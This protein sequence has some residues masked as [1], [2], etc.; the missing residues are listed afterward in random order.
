ME[1]RT[2]GTLKVVFLI[3]AIVAA[4]FGIVLLIVP[5]RVQLLV[6]WSP[7]DPVVSRVLG[8]ALLA[9]AWSSSRGWQATA[10]AQVAFLVEMETVFTVL[11]CIGLLRHLLF[12][13]TPGFAWVMFIILAAFAIA[14]IVFLVRR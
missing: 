12:L 7:I 11:G 4:L 14:W 6:G 13:P 3:H 8:A 2:F 9:L 5:G 1:K 10:R